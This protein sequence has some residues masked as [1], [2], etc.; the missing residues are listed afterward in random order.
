MKH[1]VHKTDD[2]HISSY[3]NLVLLNRL[4]S[5]IESS[6]WRKE[7]NEF[8]HNELENKGSLTCY[9]C[10]KKNLKLRSSKR[11]Q[12]ATVDHLIPKSMGGD[13]FSHTNF[14]V[15]CDSCNR[16]KGSMDHK[17]FLESDYLKKKKA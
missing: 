15:C 2:V 6:R 8:L 17:D 1:I 13:A 5:Q 3:A 14:V 4:Y 11:Q 7:R 12:K 16:R 10:N 9:Y